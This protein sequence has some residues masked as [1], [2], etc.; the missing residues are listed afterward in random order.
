MI[1][2]AP[3]TV[4]GD[5]FRLESQQLPE[6][7]NLEA[8]LSAEFW[9]VKIDFG[10]GATKPGQKKSLDGGCRRSALSCRPEQQSQGSA[11]I[12]S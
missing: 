9:R 8:G 4:F 6:K 11:S 5:F 12:A 3:W 1:R 10:V 2:R 7:S